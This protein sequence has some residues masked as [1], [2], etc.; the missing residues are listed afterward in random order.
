M[1]AESLTSP[2]LCILQWRRC[3][4]SELASEGV[5]Q[6]HSLPPSRQHRIRRMTSMSFWLLTNLEEK[7]SFSSCVVFWIV[8]QLWISHYDLSLFREIV[9]TLHA[10]GN[11]LNFNVGD[12]MKFALPNVFWTRLQGKYGT[13]RRSNIRATAKTF[14]LESDISFSPRW[15]FY[16]RLFMW[17]RT[18]LIFP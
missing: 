13:V 2:N 14:E 16:Y 15:F 6:T 11:V 5:R 7:V 1:F 17:R 8:A 4:F 10:T 3:P 9:R 18:V 12:G